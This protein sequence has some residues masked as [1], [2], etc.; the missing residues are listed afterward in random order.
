MRVSKVCYDDVERL[1]TPS[2][3][4]LKEDITGTL[5]AADKAVMK[6]TNNKIY[7]AQNISFTQRKS[8]RTTVR[9]I[10]KTKSMP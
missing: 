6:K 2:L 1:S 3:L 7:F 8:L 10:S 9:R 4:L 5:L